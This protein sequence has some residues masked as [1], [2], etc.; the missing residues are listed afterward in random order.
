MS[1][2]NMMYAIVKAKLL[3]PEVLGLLIIMPSCNRTS[4][5]P[6]VRLY[7]NKNKKFP[8]FPKTIEWEGYM[9][10]D[11]EIFPIELPYRYELSRPTPEQIK[12]IETHM[13]SP[14]HEKE[15][16]K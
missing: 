3:T 4:G 12:M 8:D 10:M 1:T 11:V 15:I 7:V 5:R 16:N 14:H 6:C 2:A 9:T 13:L